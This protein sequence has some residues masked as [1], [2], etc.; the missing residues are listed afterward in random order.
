MAVTIKFIGALRHA[1]GASTIVVNCEDC[2]VKDLICR[3]TETSPELKLNLVAEE[4]KDLRPNALVL[5]NGR[6]ISVLNG[7][8]TGLKDGDE[9]VFVPVVHGG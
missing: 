6:E 4:P 7:L 5:V 2:S 1:S 3:I 9:V 8:Q